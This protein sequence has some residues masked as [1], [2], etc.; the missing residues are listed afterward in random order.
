MLYINYIH[1]H[2]IRGPPYSILC[3]KPA[4]KDTNEAMMVLAPAGTFCLLSWHMLLVCVCVRVFLGLMFDAYGF[5]K[6][7]RFVRH[8]YI[9]CSNSRC[10]M[11]VD[12]VLC[13][14]FFHSP[15]H[16]RIIPATLQSPFASRTSRRT[17]LSCPFPAYPIQCR[18]FCATNFC[19]PILCSSVSLCLAL[20]LFWAQ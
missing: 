17:P 20:T 3:V 14:Y 12:P 9:M 7:K 8:I 19:D 2:I 18:I 6:C 10:F 1:M 13:L 11:Y 16:R 15:P 4:A 5:R